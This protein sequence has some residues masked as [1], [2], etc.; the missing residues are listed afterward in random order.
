MYVILMG[1]V[2]YPQYRTLI[3]A[4]G[5]GLLLLLLI[6]I[7]IRNRLRRSRSVLPGL[8]SY[9]PQNPGTAPGTASAVDSED[10]LPEPPMPEDR[11]TRIRPAGSTSRD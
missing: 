1:L 7:Q 6:G 3:G 2:L 9:S 4:V 11:Q 5:L 10:D 8:S